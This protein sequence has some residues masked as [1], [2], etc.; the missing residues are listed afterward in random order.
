MGFVALSAYI[1]AIPCLMSGAQIAKGGKARAFIDRS[2]LRD[3]PF[4][5]FSFGQLF[6]FWGYLP[7]FFYIPTFAEVSLRTGSTKA[8]YLLVGAQ[9][10]SLGGRMVV[11]VIAHYLGVMAPWIASASI[12]GILAFAWLGITDLSGLTAFAVLYGK[13]LIHVILLS[14]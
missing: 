6:A 2:A 4:L 1:V 12:S 7:P 8:F 14:V 9:A 3:I 5:T 10:A 11:A 13:H